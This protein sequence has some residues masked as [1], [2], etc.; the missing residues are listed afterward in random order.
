VNTNGAASGVVGAAL[1]ERLA[2]LEP[3]TRDVLSVAAAMGT[4]F[5]VAMLTASLDVDLDAVHAAL[6]VAQDAGFVLGPNDT[7][8]RFRHA[9]TREVVYEQLDAARRKDIHARILRALERDG[10]ESVHELAHHAWAAD[11]LAR[12]IAYNERAGDAALELRAFSDA[13]INY[14]RAEVLAVRALERARARLSM[15]ALLQGKD[16]TSISS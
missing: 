15:V 10:A 1:R 4:T 16:P 5:G 3:A 8:Y 9:L 14:A 2:G 7:G 12:G 6:A 13:A 11:D